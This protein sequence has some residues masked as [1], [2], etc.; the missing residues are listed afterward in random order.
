MRSSALQSNFEREG[1]MARKFC[2][3]PTWWVRTDAGMKEFPGGEASGKNI[4]ALKCVFG[5]S[6]AVDFHTRKA[7]LSLSDLE[8]LTG[9]SRPMVIRGLKTLEELKIVKIGKD[10][11]VHEY[12]LTVLNTD[13]NWGKVPYD[14]VLKQLPTMPNRGAIPL[15]ALKIYFLLIALRPNK[16]ETVSIGYDTIEQYLGCQ[17]AH[18]RPALDILY[19]HTLISVALEG[20]ERRRR[21]NAY[22]ILGL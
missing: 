1:L 5:L 16:Y 19:T 18:I 20:E 14:R 10:G 8:K 11:H 3:C 15:T 12:E 7:K 22:Q 2:M 13:E 6:T 21:H 4:A 17:R 9:L